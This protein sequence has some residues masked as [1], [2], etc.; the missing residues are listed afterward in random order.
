[1]MLLTDIEE[2]HKLLLDLLEFGGIL[3]VGIFKVLERAARVHIVARVDAHLLTVKGCDI[4][5]MGREMDVGY[6]GRL[7]TVGLQLG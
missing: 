7:I 2:G 1:M 3:F 6:E 4:G 5:R